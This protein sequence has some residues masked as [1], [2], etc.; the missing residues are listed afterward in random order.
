MILGLVLLTK[1]NASKGGQTSLD[2][3]TEMNLFERL[4][5]ETGGGTAMTWAKVGQKHAVN[6]VQVMRRGTCET[7]G[8]AIPQW[9]KETGFGNAS[10]PDPKWRD[11][12]CV[13]LDPVGDGE[14][15]FVAGQ[16]LINACIKLVVDNSDVVSKMTEDMGVST[17]HFSTGVLVE[18]A[19]TTVDKKT[20]HILIQK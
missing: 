11:K 16:T 20:H 12:A 8:Y 5:A 3:E 9:A 15:V 2:S 10:K 17:C 13:L 18:I 4:L 1:N 6:A 14:K 19:E 7:L